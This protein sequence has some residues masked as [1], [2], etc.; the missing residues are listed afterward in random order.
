MP[1]RFTNEFDDRL[2]N[3]DLLID[4]GMEV[5]SAGVFRI[6][7]NLFDNA[8]VAFGWA[9]FEGELQ[10][11]R[12]IVSLRYYGLLFHDTQAAGPYVLKGLYGYRLRPGH[13]PN[14]EDI[15]ELAN[16]YRTTGHYKLI[17]FRSD[18]NDSSQ[19]QKMIRLYEE[20]ERRGVKLT[21]PEYTGDG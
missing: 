18:Q 7:G 2:D 6:D 17:S 13:I 5:I 4:V 1:A 20:A 21:Q 16:E 19:R 12:A 15:P 14:R 9:R 8:G 10:P 11:G 3:G